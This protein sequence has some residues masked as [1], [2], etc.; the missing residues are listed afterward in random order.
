MR[1]I[2]CT[3]VS[4]AMSAVLMAAVVMGAAVSAP[5]SA[6]SGAAKDVRAM[7]SL[8]DKG[9]TVK[10]LDG[11]TITAAEIDATVT[12]LLKAA[13]VPGAG[14]VIINGGRVVFAKGYGL[15]DKEKNLPLTEN[16]VMSGASFT[17][18]V[19][20]YMALKLVDRGVLDLDKPVYEYLPK[21]LP[22]YD[23]YKDL[24]G[25]ERY[26]L[27]TA[28]MLLDHT[29]GFPNYRWINGDRKLNINFEPGSRFAYSG[30]GINLLQFVIE[31]IT[32]RPL[33]DLMQENVFQ[34]LGMTWSSMVWQARFEDDYANG[35]DEYGRSLGPLR[36]KNPNAAGS[37]STTPL[38]FARF[39]QAILDAEGLRTRT[40]G[41]MLSAQ[42]PI[43]AKHEF[44]TMENQ[45][46]D[47]NKSIRLSYGLGW[48]LYWS[49]H[50]EA[51]FKEGHDDGWRNY[52]V[53]F[54][55]PKAGMIIMT[56]SGNGEG[57]YKELLEK[58]LADTYTP[59][60]WERFTPYDQLPPRLVL[61]QHTKVSVDAQTLEKYVGRYGTPPKLILV[62]RH[63]GNHLT[64]QENDEP[65]QELDPESA[66]QFFSTVADDVYTFEMDP[67]GRVT[68]IVLRSGDETIPINRID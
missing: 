36:W 14:I 61:K 32:K 54:R 46:T 59:I 41:R 18:V 53:G 66:T 6:K 8:E 56:N 2:N 64:L 57:I 13:Q 50:G 58:V 16:T 30:E 51:L 1:K 4:A 29:G 35:Y 45:L 47:E 60:E 43:L 38:D 23:F 39:V 21:P 3:A 17:K 49:P 20:A 11:S 52:C 26:K 10:R 7:N 15:R 5:S 48:G 44:P 25:D 28:R 24:A 65:V 37:L 31:T 40:W 63:E 19:F 9:P 55:M 12:R 67:S 68:R 22:E 27:I 33:Q 62:V 34:P 42:I